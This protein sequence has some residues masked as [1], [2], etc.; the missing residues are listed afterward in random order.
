[1]FAFGKERARNLVMR[2]RGRCDGSR[3]D[4]SDEFVEGL[5]RCGAEL[6]RNGAI[7]DRID[8]IDCGELSGPNLR[9]QPRMIAPDMANPNNTNAQIFHPLRA[10][11][12]RTFGGQTYLTP[13]RR[14]RR[15]RSSCNA[16]PIRHSHGTLRTFALSR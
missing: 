11:N 2:V 6:Y 5:C 7:A 15:I 4:Q 13:M 1:M 3:I 9:I 14:M 12:A 10:V 16:S 8:V